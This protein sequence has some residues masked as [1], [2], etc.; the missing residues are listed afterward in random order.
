MSKKQLVPVVSQH[1]RKIHTI[2][3]SRNDCI[4]AETCVEIAPLA[5]EMDSE[6]IAVVKASAL[7]MSDDFLLIAAQACPTQAIMLFD[8][9]GNQIF[10]IVH[11]Q[12]K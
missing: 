8:E 12:D 7:Q 10:P 1:K 4:S 9:D 3:V 5:F 2:K 6:N 11:K